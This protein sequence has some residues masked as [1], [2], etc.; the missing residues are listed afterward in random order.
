MV[1]KLEK[2]EKIQ[3]NGKYFLCVHLAFYRSIASHRMQSVRLY[4][5]N[6]QLYDFHGHANVVDWSI[7]SI[8]FSLLD[9][10]NNV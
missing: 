1:I 5:F 4:A 2:Q 3:E 9:A 10:F 8:G 7:T 6:R